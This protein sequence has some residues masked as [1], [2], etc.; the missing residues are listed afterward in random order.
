MQKFPLHALVLKPS[1]IN[2]FVF[3]ES[4]GGEDRKRSEEVCGCQIRERI[5]SHGPDILFLS[6][7]P[8]LSSL[9]YCWHGF[10]MWSPESRPHSPPQVS[11]NFSCTFSADYFFEKCTCWSLS[12]F[13]PVEFHPIGWNES[14]NLAKSLWIMLLS[15]I[16]VTTP[17]SFM[18]S[19]NFTNIPLSLCFNPAHS[20]KR[21]LSK[22]NLWSSP[23]TRN[24]N[25]AS[26]RD[27]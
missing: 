16:I 2:R 8:R 4:G 22:I 21:A 6:T 18:S 20:N 1:E 12:F 25:M 9:I 5:I 27:K 13:F 19:E 14:P 3:W 15:S 24:L 11:G 23:R 17:P 10:N 26:H 7:E